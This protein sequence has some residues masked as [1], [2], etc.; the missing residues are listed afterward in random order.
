MR[1]RARAPAGHA[2]LVERSLE[3]LVAEARGHHLDHLVEA[4][5]RQSARLTAARHRF[6]RHAAVAGRVG[7]DGWWEVEALAR[8][9]GRAASH[10]R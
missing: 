6:T 2:D 3:Q 10:P 4:A 8:S 9:A 5:L 1:P 7:T